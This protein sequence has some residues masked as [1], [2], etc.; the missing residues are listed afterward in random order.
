MA[1]RFVIAYF[2][3]YDSV[4]LTNSNR[5]FSCRLVISEAHKDYSLKLKKRFCFW[6]D[7]NIRS[8]LYIHP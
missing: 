4:L 7:Y 5:I 6:Y 8:L 1:N 3:E 2:L